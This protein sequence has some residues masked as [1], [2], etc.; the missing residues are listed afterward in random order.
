MANIFNAAEAIDVGI[1]KER[2][3]R[4]FYGYVAEKFKDKEMK[5]LFSRLKEWEEAH[6]KKF[7]EIR[8]TL[9]ESEATES[10]KG[11]FAAYAKAAVDDLLYKQVSPEWFAK[12][13]HEPLIAVR[14][15]IGFEKDAILFFNELLRYMAPRHREK[16]GELIE[17]EKKHLVYLSE[18]KRKMEETEKPLSHEMNTQLAIIKEGVSIIQDKTPG[19]INEAQARI[20]TT[21]RNSIDRLAKMVGSVR[22]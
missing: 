3:R 1:E 13:V 2:K 20:L 11:E 10:Y 19:P 12:N 17:E 16:I 9:E 6:I 5:D 8:A 22:P 21:I 4:D 18:M 15:G 7:S 14:Y